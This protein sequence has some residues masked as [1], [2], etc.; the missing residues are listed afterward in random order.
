M[1]TESSGRKPGDKARLTSP[2]YKDP[3]AVCVKFY[4][5]MYGDGMGTLNV[6]AKVSR[7]SWPLYVGSGCPMDPPSF[8]T[9]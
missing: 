2:V 4:Y 6:Y 7:L 8:P 3:G 9:S 5:H 1:F